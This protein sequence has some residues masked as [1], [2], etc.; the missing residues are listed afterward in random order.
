M[1]GG[2]SQGVRRE[3]QQGIGV[4]QIVLTQ[5]VQVVLQQ[6]GEVFEFAPEGRA[7]G[8]KRGQSAEAFGGQTAP[9]QLAQLD[10][11]PAR[12]ARQARAGAEDLQFLPP[13]RQ[14]RAQDHRASLFGQ[15]RRSGPAQLFEDK[16]GQTLEG[17]NL[18]AGVSGHRRI[19]QELP[20]QLEG[21]LLGRQQ[22]ERRAVR[23]R[24][25]GLANF[26]QTLESLSRSGGSEQKARLHPVVV[27][28]DGGGRCQRFVHGE[29]NR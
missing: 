21:G 26:R 23:L 3:V 19:G 24:Q 14:Q 8:G 22:Q 9:L 2:P 18:Q 27:A 20:F 5:P 7:R 17:E 28:R 15:Q 16:I 11:E 25:K 1:G 12:E 4:A 13:P 6:A 29:A 10:T